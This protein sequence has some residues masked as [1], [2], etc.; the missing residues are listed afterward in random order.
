LRRLE[1]KTIRKNFVLCFSCKVFHSSYLYNQ[2]ATSEQYG[3]QDPLA[4][5]NEKLLHM[6]LMDQN[7]DKIQATVK[8]PY[9]SIFVDDLYVGGAFCMTSFSVVPN[10]GIMKMTHHRFKLLFQKGTTVIPEPSLQIRDSGFSFCSMF[11][12]L[13]KKSDYHYLIDFIGVITSVRHQTEVDY[14]GKKL[15]LMILEIYADG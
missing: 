13:E 3:R 5:D 15:K 1:T 12:I 11:E 6:I 4:E 2:N 7:L 10:I 14:Y 8:E 9:I